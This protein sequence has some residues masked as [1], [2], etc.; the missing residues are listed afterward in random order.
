MD[1]ILQ[2]Q[3]TGHMFSLLL[4]QDVPLFCELPMGP[5][6]CL[7]LRQE[8][9]RV[10]ARLRLNIRFPHLCPASFLEKAEW[11]NC[12]LTN[13]RVQRTKS[14]YKLGTYLLSFRV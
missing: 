6:E 11:R 7:E 3:D 9:Q 2:L 10:R 1:I 12:Y 4:A 8:R 13:A 5:R 14:Y